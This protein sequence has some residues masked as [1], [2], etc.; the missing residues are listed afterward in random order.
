MTVQNEVT[1]LIDVIQTNWPGV[2]FPSALALRNRDEP[3]TIYPDGETIREQAV[4]LDAYYAASLAHGATTREFYGNDPQYDVTTTVD[5]WVQ[6]K[7]DETW[8]EAD[9]IDAFRTLVAYVQNAINTQLTYPEVD[10]GDDDTGRVV[11]LDL[12]I[13]DTDHRSREFKDQY[14]TDF[15]VEFRGREQTP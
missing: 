15:T 4:N 14:R 1:W 7:S 8:G 9:D 11:Y 5:V 2:E 13:A 12:R 3:L 6:A 10:T